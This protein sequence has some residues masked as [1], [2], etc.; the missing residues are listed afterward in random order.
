MKFLQE[1]ALS[2]KSILRI[3]AAALFLSIASIVVLTVILVAGGTDKRIGVVRSNNLIQG[4]KAMQDAQERYENKQKVWQTSISTLEGELQSAVENYRA[5]YASLSKDEIRKQELAIEQK[6][7]NYIQYS[8][9]IKEKVETEENGM[10]Q[11]VLNQIN[12]FVEQYG[13]EHG[14][15]VILGTTAAGN[16]LY[17]TES[18]DITDEV[19]KALNDTYTSGNNGVQNV[20]Q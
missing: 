10:M 2:Q 11:G 3:A 1:P 5:M 8:Q 12:S 13:K 7:A 6:R 19:L 17:G 16:V 20:S 9:S 18:I 14:F 4:Y 15:D